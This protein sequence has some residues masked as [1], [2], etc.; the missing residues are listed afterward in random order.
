MLFGETKERFIIR[1]PYTL[2]WARV[3][4]AT[5]AF[6]IQGSFL[7]LL[8]VP[9][10]LRVA[11]ASGVSTPSAPPPPAPTPSRE[12]FSVRKSCK[13]TPAY[14]GRRLCGAAPCAALGAADR[15]DLEASARGSSYTPAS[16]PSPGGRRLPGC[17]DRSLSGGSCGPEWPHRDS[18]SKSELRDK[19]ALKTT[20]FDLSES[21]F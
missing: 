13:M 14:A 6:G 9:P 11:E 19:K 16:G 4:S 2:P 21:H 1:H 17:R 3:S 10:P 8:T 7:N 20:G 15:P 18:D 12:K 5:S